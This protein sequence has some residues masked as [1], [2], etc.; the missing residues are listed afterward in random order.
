[1]REHTRRNAEALD[2]SQ[3]LS[4]NGEQDAAFDEYL[5]GTGLQ[6]SPS[7]GLNVDAYKRFILRGGLSKWI[8]K[9]KLKSQRSLKLLQLEV[10]AS[11]RLQEWKSSICLAQWV[12]Y[13]SLQQLRVYSARRTELKLSIGMLYRYKIRT[14]LHYWKLRVEVRRQKKTRL[15][16][17]W[18][19]LLRGRF[20]VKMVSSQSEYIQSAACQI[21][22]C[23]LQP[24]SARPHG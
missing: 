3:S 11:L 12:N 20:L 19:H 14:C 7:K 23:I 6:R 13:V 22:N 24:D 9:H 17:L 21:T 5:R 10:N 1:M 16:S 15:F 4:L 8:R 18:K 2:W